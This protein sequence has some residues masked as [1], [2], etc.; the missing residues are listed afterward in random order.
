MLQHYKA[1]DA[2][3]TGS[4]LPMF[5]D[6]KPTR[7]LN[8]GLVLLSF[9]T[10]FRPQKPKALQTFDVICDCPYTDMAVPSSTPN[11]GD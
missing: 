4:T 5:V 10:N 9:E 3:S 7:L 11:L 2:G 8:V 6:V 1:G